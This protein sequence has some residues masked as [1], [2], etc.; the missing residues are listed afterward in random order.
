MAYLGNSPKGNLLTMNS[1]QFTG[2]GST[3]NF[4]LSQSVGNTNEI[5]VFVGNVRQDPHSAYTVSG[6]TTLS[7]TAAPPAG[8]NNIYVVY[9]GKSLGENTP[10]ENSIEFGMIKAINGGYE[11]KATISSTFTVDASDNMMVCGPVSYTGTVT[12][13]GTLTVV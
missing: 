9:I 4:T 13:N 7:F 2:N 10:G 5:E 3:T 1:S 12:V 8:T 11:N 6:G